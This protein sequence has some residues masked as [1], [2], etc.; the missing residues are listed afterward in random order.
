M[1]GKKKVKSLKK[2]FSLN[3]DLNVN[4]A[5]FKK[6]QYVA[7]FGLVFDMYTHLVMH[8]F[9]EWKA[10]VVPNKSQILSLYFVSFQWI[11]HTENFKAHNK[12]K[13]FRSIFFCYF[14]SSYSD[15]KIF[16]TSFWNWIVACLYKSIEFFLF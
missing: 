12:I 1:S 8:F 7:L 4:Y 6:L 15:T 9:L 2:S 16:T 3:H 13:N 11:H 5:I 10:S 14:L